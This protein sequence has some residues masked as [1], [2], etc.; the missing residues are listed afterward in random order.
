MLY[1]VLIVQGSIHVAVAAVVALLPRVSEQESFVVPRRVS[2][3]GS[4]SE[5]LL[6]I[7]SRVSETGGFVDSLATRGLN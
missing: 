3:F 5:F 6:I 7:E 2:F 4:S 1:S